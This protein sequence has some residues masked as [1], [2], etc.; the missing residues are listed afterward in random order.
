M[1]S[2]SLTGSPFPLLLIN[3]AERISRN[4][5]GCGTT[6]QVVFPLIGNAMQTSRRELRPD[7]V[8][9]DGK[10]FDLT[11]TLAQQKSEV[12]NELEDIFRLAGAKAGETM[13]HRNET[14]QE[15]QQDSEGLRA[16]AAEAEL[17]YTTSSFTCSFCYRNF[18]A[19]K[20]L[21][22]HI[23]TVHGPKSFSCSHCRIKF[24]RKDTRDRHDTEKHSNLDNI[25]RCL[26]CE[27]Y[28]S[29]RAFTEHRDSEVRYSWVFSILTVWADLPVL[30]ACFAL[31]FSIGDKS[32][33][34]ILNDLEIR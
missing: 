34:T 30:P 14:F 24:T 32:S 11:H 22:R 28:V 7:G 31:C 25:I 9:L 5:G 29:K 27:R 10:D 1:G 21:L 3:L 26:A 13:E 20:S 6:E 2:L 18:S 19:K 12:F 23:R 8:W 33:C 15:T 17:Q 4:P 16:T